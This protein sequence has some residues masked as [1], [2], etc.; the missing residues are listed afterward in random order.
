MY[1]SCDQLGYFV[2]IILVCKFQA[3]RT[4]RELLDLYIYMGTNVTVRV[5]VDDKVNDSPCGLSTD[6][7]KLSYCG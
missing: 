4:E 1:Q 3:R 6:A 2:L 5:H 7:V